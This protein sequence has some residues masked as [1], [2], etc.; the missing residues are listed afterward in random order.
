MYLSNHMIT[1]SSHMLNVRFLK[2]YTYD[3]KKPNMAL[4]SRNIAT[5]G[6]FLETANMN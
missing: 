2:L 6:K 4:N 3:N 1:I 5:W